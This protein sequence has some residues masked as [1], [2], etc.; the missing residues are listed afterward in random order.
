MDTATCSSQKFRLFL[1]KIPV[2]EKTTTEPILSASFDYTR[3]MNRLKDVVL[4]IKNQNSETSDLDMKLLEESAKEIMTRMP[5]FMPKYPGFHQYR[6]KDSIA[7]A[8][9]KYLPKEFHHEKFVAIR[10]N[11]NGR[12][13]P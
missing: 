8:Y 12:K 11:P 10:T 9:I 4:R 3:E 5:K 1:E 13:C 6:Q 2:R 7:Q